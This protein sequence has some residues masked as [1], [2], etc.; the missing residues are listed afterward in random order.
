[1]I[2]NL[3]LILI[4]ISNQIINNLKINNYCKLITKILKNKIKNLEINVKNINY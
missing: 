3:I 4:T 1:M 2:I